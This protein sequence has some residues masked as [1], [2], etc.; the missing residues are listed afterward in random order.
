[1]IWPAL[2]MEVRT[3]GDAHCPVGAAALSLQQRVSWQPG[4]PLG[5]GEEEDPAFVVPPGDMV[6][7]D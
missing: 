7:L 6:T 5:A 1:M 3:C 2:E 4:L